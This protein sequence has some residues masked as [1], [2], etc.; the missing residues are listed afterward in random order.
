[1]TVMVQTGG[2]PSLIA[3]LFAPLGAVVIV[4]LL[5][6]ASFLVHPF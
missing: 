5:L 4:I 3:G 6:A 2:S 1:M